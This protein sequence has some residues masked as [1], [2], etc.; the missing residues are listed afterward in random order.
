MR[1]EPLPGRILAKDMKSGERKVGSIIIM[2]D[3]KRTAGIRPRWLQVWQTGDGVTSVLPGHWILVE[4]GRWS[5][6]MEIELDGNEISIWAV[7]PNG[8][9]MSS[10]TDPRDEMV[11]E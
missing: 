10:E 1:V 5:R 8:I 11:N 2:D 4:H 6:K 3:D 7:D 9:I